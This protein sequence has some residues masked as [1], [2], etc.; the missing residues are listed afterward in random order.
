MTGTAPVVPGPGVRHPVLECVA[1]AFAARPGASARAV[2]WATVGAIPAAVLG[3]AVAHALDD[4]FLAGHATRGLVWLAVPVAGTVLAALVAARSVRAV[5]DLVE[6]FRDHLVDRVVST[7]LTD[8]VNAAGPRPAGA[9][10]AR[11]VQQIEGVR[12]SFASGVATVL[13]IVTTLLGSF[14]GEGE[15]SP[16]ALLITLPPV[17]LAL[18]LFAL[19]V[20]AVLRRQRALVV[21]QDALSGTL[22]T[23]LAGLRDIRA[24]GAQDWAIA[25]CGARIDAQNS[26]A[27]SAASITS[28][29][30]LIVGLGGRAPAALFLLATPWLLRHGTSPGAVA[31]SLTYLVGTVQT[32][33][34]ALSDA[35]GS[36]L[37]PMWVTL[38]N[39]L[40]DRPPAEPE[41]APPVPHCRCGQGPAVPVSTQGLSF[42]YGPHA[43]PVVRELNLQVPAG[44]HLAVVGA[45]GIGKS[46]LAGLICGQLI[47][48]AGTVRVGGVDPA[49]LPPAE[50][51][52]LRVL[53][54]QEAY[55]FSGSLADNLRYLRPDADDTALDVAVAAVGMTALRDRLGGYAAPVAPAAL[56][57]GERQLVALT[58]AWLSRA[59]LLVLDE[60]T[61]HLDPVAEAR[62]EEA[63]ARRPGTLIVIAHRISS[64]RRADR[65]LVMDGT[66][67]TIGTHARLLSASPLYRDLVGHWQPVTEALPVPELNGC[68]TRT[69]VLVGS[70]WRVNL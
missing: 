52:L 33:V 26:A 54:P 17:L 32:T 8:A 63:F 29:R 5:G 14:I 60:A 45:S 20:P 10:V 40:G 68:T 56:S 31:G 66:D 57:A 4:G 53:I 42:A 48:G 70:P 43:E 18:G 12:L 13:A 21:G 62:A 44:E 37:I 16:V 35:L 36:A 67:A 7:T 11:V 15:I 64:A 22:E 51:G 6:P 50:R 61:C 38:E 65:I 59:P 47:P 27:G 19:T 2:G 34:Q 55:V 28:L 30:L 25:D 3:W 49:A 58:R 9:N 23:D 41:P 24:A 1:G 39:L 69:P 46:T